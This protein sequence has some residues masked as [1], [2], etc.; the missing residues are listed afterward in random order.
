MSNLPALSPAEENCLIIAELVKDT[1]QNF[2][3]LGFLLK[4][5]RDNAYWS[6]GARCDSFRDFIE[7]LGLHSYSWVTRLIDMAEIVSKQLLTQEEIQEVGVTKMALLLPLIKRE[8]LT[9][10]IMAVAKNGTAQDLRLVLRKRSK[11]DEPN[12]RK[13]TGTIICE[14]CGFVIDYYPGKEHWS[15]I[16]R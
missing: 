10:E 14:R 16:K 9:D 5:N 1:K 7:M 12:E 3:T 6:S 2:L 4:E 15:E 8:N 13:P 11:D